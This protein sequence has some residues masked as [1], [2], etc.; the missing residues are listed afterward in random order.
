MG[1]K[2][3]IGL[4]SSTGSILR[5]VVR[6]LEA[7]DD[8]GADAGR[9]VLVEERV[10][11]PEHDPDRGQ[12]VG[13]HRAEERQPPHDANDRAKVPLK[14]PPPDLRRVLAANL[15]FGPK[16]VAPIRRTNG[17]SVNKNVRLPRSCS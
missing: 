12:E 15:A 14:L 9:V 4:R 17:S 2:T 7:A 8:P 3:K 6:E 11:A 5:H 1:S 16:H 10:Q 13:V